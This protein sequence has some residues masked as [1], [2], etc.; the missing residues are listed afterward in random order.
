MNI[1]ITLPR[2]LIECI[3]RGEKHYEMRKVIPKHMKLGEDGFFVVEKGTN[4]IRCWCRVDQ[5]N[6]IFVDHY[7]VDNY[8]DILCVRPEYILNYVGEK[9]AYLWKIGKVIKFV[10]LERNSLIVDKNPQSFAY[11]PLSYGESF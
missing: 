11:C 4:N 7:T 10:D 6:R 2:P 3:I 5:I 8:V 9:G 1:L